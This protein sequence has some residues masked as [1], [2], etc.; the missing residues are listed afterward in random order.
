MRQS[1]AS[2]KVGET[3]FY[4]D[5]KHFLIYPT[6]DH[7]SPFNS[8]AIIRNFFPYAE[9]RIRSFASSTTARSAGRFPSIQSSRI[10]VA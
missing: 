8:I 6:I 10:R 2:P 3:F 9:S 1:P 7:N 4:I 5:Y